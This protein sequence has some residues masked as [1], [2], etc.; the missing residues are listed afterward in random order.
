MD[1][2]APGGVNFFLSN[3]LSHWLFLF[4][5]SIAGAL[6]SS[7]L[8]GLPLVSAVD[9]ILSLQLI[10]IAL[11]LVAISVALLETMLV[12]RNFSALI[13]S[14]AA[15][16]ICALLPLSSVAGFGTYALVTGDE[17]GGASFVYVPMVRVYLQALLF[18]GL[19]PEHLQDPTVLGL[20]P[21]EVW[22]GERSAATGVIQIYLILTS[23]ILSTLATILFR[24]RKQPR[25]IVWPD[26]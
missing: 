11:W 21:V 25:A 12:T 5:L 8:F 22:A 7:G 23:I 26:S 2:N 6:V 9:A 17:I 20:V 24:T 10:F 14:L 16:T 15:L 13:K 19:I 4:F 18:I 3:A 1:S